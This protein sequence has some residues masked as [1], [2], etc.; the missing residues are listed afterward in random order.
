MNGKRLFLVLITC[1]T[2]SAYVPNDPD[3]P[4]NFLSE[5]EKLA[6]EWATN[7]SKRFE[8]ETVKIQFSNTDESATKRKSSLS[9]LSRYCACAL[10]VAFMFDALNVKISNGTLHYSFRP[11]S[12]AFKW[13]RKSSIPIECVLRLIGL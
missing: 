12:T 7:G 4:E 8:D 11:A 13:F 1:T 9:S 2:L 6:E 3:Y 5:D 10:I